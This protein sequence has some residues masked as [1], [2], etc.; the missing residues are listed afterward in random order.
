MK[1]RSFYATNKARSFYLLGY[2]AI[3]SSIFVLEF[4]G[5]LWNLVEMTN[6]LGQFRVTANR[7]SEHLKNVPWQT[8]IMNQKLIEHNQSGKEG[9]KMPRMPDFGFP[10]WISPTIYRGFSRRFAPSLLQHH[11]TNKNAKMNTEV[12]IVAGKLIKRS[13]GL[14]ERYQSELGKLNGPEKYALAIEV[15]RL[16]QEQQ[17]QISFAVQVQK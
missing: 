9:S 4:G 1:N 6:Q 2:Y 5:V 3:F 8:T 16:T 11:D 14:R 7:E 17:E 12:A 15:A 13:Q 10:P